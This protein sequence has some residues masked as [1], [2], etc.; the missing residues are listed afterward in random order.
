[1]SHNGLVMRQGQAL[2][3]ILLVLAVA[4]TVGLSI[5]SRSITEVSVSTAQEESARA[6]AAAEAGVEATVAN[7]TL[8]PGDFSAISATVNVVANPQGQLPEIHLGDSLKAGEVATVFLA[9]HDAN[10]NFPT[11]PLYPRDNIFV[12]WGSSNQPALEA[13]FYYQ[14]GTAVAVNRDVYDPQ[15]TGRTPGSKAPTSPAAD[16]PS[17]HNYSYSAQLNLPG[18]GYAVGATPLF[19]RLKLLY[20]PATGHPLGV[21]APAG[22]QFPG[23]GK[24]IISTGTSG[25]SNVRIRGLL[26]YAQ[27]PTQFD[28][29]L[30]SGT[31]DL[32]K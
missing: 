14:N 25:S 21:R 8:A 9:A 18:L 15:G 31:G 30:F 13:I 5:A 10:D 29:A 16:C 22:M 19:M 20:N 1:M 12:C 3:I 28:N 27:A 11:A 23:Q 24:E 17:G 2:V 26:E 4:L 6:L 32:T 7:V